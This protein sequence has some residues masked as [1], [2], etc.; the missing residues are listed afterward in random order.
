MSRLITAS[1]FSSINWFQSCPPSWKERATKDLHNSLARIWTDPNKAAQRGIDFERRAY[2]IL[3]KGVDIDKVK[4][5]ELFKKMLRQI[6]GGVFQKK[7]KRFI[8]VGGEEYCLYGKIDVS[9]PNKIID[10]KTTGRYKGRDNYLKSMQHI[11]YCFNERISEFEYLVAEFDGDDGPMED[12]HTI[13]FHVDDPKSLEP[14]IRERIAETMAFLET[15][16]EL[17]DLYLTQF[18]RY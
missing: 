11:I 3:E 2:A 14:V 1:L 18:S 10:V 5:S 6:Q 15:D 17:W 12:L 4:S 13:P 7:T 8:E 9:F 16:K